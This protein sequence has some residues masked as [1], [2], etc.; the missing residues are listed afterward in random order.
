MHKNNR[1]ALF[2]N[3][4]L[5]RMEIN[6]PPVV[7][8]QRVGNEFD[9][10]QIGEK[11]EKRITG[12]G[13]ENFISRTCEEAKNKRVCFAGA[14]GQEQFFRIDGFAVIAIVGGD[15]F[16]RSEQPFRL[17]IILERVGIFQRVE[18]SG[19]IVGQACACGI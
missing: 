2:G 10:L 3:R 18:N 14:G 6:L 1:A 12:L 9:V 4:L 11:I 5:K 8:N 19:R 7:I 15:S 16:A 17:R 13:D